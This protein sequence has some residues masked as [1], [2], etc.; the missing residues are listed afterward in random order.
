[1]QRKSINTCAAVL[2]AVLLAGHGLPAYAGTDDGVRC[3]TGYTSNWNS[4]T[5]VLRCSKVSTT[6]VVTVCPPPPSPF[7]HYNDPEGRDRCTLPS[8]PYVGNMAPNQYVNAVCSLPGYTYKNDVLT[9]DRDR[10]EKT[11]TLYAYP[12]QL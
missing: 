12:N 5:K 4:S 9:S 2:T 11:D 10:C 6:W 1:M 8:V 3:P 7:S